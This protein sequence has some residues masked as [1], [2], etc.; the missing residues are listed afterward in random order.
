[1]DVNTLDALLQK[2]TPHQLKIIQALYHSDGRWL[3]RIGLAKAIGRKRLTPYDIDILKM[4]TEKGLIL[5]STR[6]TSAPGS[7]FAYIHNMPDEIADL[8]QQ[9]SEYRDNHPLYRVVHRKR[10]RLIEEV[11]EQTHGTQLHRPLE[12]WSAEQVKER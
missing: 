2:M 1:M 5:T 7:E 10:I 12:P 4:L 11:V 9:W 8:L 6:P 3:T